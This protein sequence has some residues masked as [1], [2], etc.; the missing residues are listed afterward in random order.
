MSCSA[1]KNCDYHCVTLSLYF[2]FPPWK[3]HQHWRSRHA[4]STWCPS[5]IFLQGHGSGS[6]GKKWRTLCTVNNF[7]KITHLTCVCKGLKL[8]PLISGKKANKHTWLVDFTTL[9]S[10]QTI[11]T[12]TLVISIRPALMQ[13]SGS[14]LGTYSYVCTQCRTVTSK[15][16]AFAL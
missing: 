5:L 9:P 10:F 13:L 12:T 7:R 16:I 1:S 2:F 11:H 3:T 6:E 4:H 14:I 15:C 8:V